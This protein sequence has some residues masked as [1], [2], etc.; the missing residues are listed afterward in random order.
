MRHG[1]IDSVSP[2]IEWRGLI[3]IVQEVIF[4]DIAFPLLILVKN[5]E[6]IRPG[7]F[8]DVALP[9]LVSVKNVMPVLQTVFLHVT[10]GLAI[11]GVY[12]CAIRQRVFFEYKAPR[13]NHIAKVKAQNRSI[14][15]PHPFQP[16]LA[17]SPVYP[18][19]NST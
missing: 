11:F 1:Q 2:F 14:H 17:K 7:V 16:S 4:L 8:L 12:L 5:I 15:L 19:N 3:G 10:D 9:L 13:Q 18:W 6:P